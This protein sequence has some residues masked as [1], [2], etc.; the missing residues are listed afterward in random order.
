MSYALRVYIPF[1][2]KWW[3]DSFEPPK[4]D[5]QSTKAD[6]IIAEDASTLEIVFKPEIK[7]AIIL[8]NRGKIKRTS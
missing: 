6:D 1:I 2:L 3:T 7:D 4:H 5:V 8:W